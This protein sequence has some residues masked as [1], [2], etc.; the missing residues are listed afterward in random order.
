MLIELLLVVLPLLHWTL[1]CAARSSIALVFFQRKLAVVEKP[2]P[3]A[4]VCKIVFLEFLRLL[5]LLSFNG[6]LPAI[7]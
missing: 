4:L 5:W 6:S 2:C 7:A 3:S 1:L